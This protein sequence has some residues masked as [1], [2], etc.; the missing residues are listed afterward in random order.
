MCA[1]KA[2]SL[3]FPVDWVEP[4]AVFRTGINVSVTRWPGRRF[5]RPLRRRPRRNHTDTAALTKR[6]GV[7]GGGGRGKGSPKTPLMNMESL[8]RSAGNG[9]VSAASPVSPASPA[10]WSGQVRADYFERTVGVAA[11][12]SDTEQSEGGGGARHTTQTKAARTLRR[13]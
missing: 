7:G 3:R 5:A 6:G 1:M 10:S 2:S 12:R 11:G 8:F 9:L 4:H 13:L